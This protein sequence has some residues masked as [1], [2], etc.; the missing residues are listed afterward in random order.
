MNVIESLDDF[1]TEVLNSEKRVMVDF[2]GNWCGPCKQMKPILEDLSEE[3]NISKVDIDSNPEIADKY[4]VMSLPTFVI[5]E[6]GKEKR[7]KTGF[8]D[9]DKLK[10]FYQE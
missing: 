2:F 4:S 5:F 3:L 1:K 8:V 10:K 9:K 7:R 6:D